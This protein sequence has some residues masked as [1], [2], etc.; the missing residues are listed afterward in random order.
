MFAIRYENDLDGTFVVS[1]NL[2]LSLQAILLIAKT[3][4]LIAVES[5]QQAL[6]KA[7]ARGLATESRFPATKNSRFKVSSFINRNFNFVILP[8]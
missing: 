5:P 2:I 4:A 8:S 3:I 7:S 1:K 6:K